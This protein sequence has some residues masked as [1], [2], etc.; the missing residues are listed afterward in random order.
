MDTALK[1]R[2]IG[3]IVLVALA[4]IFLPMLVKGPAPS[5][6]VAD[7][8]LEA[9]AAPANGQFETRE[10][11][12]VTPGDAPAGG[13]LGMRGAASAPAAVQDNPDAADLANPS[14]APS[15]PEV[16][17]GNY[18]VN[19]GA[20]ATSAD[21]DAVLARLKQ[22][23]LPGFSEKTQING[24][25]AW[26]VRVGPYVDQAQA[27]SARLQ[28]VKVRSDVNAQVVT[29]DANAAAPAPAAS[30][31][32]PAPAAKPSSSVAA[33]S[34]AAPTKTESLPPEPAKP[35]AA[36]PKPAEAPKPAPAKPD[37][38][39]TEPA[40]PEPT[41]PAVAAPAAPAAPAASSVGFA[42]QLGAFGRAEDAD[43]LRDRVRA[44]GFSAFVEQVRTD[45][46][47]LNRVRVG[48]VANRGDAEQLRAQ[49]A[50]KV[51]ISG[52]V[53]PHP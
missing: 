4:V 15:A 49:V 42:V 23:Q 1:Q 8:P 41:K 33:A 32:T 21:A 34:T 29:L 27:E 31:P 16:A 3:A 48:P 53:R 17:A 52:M 5:S 25:P 44:A 11:P 10:L 40:K 51:G 46:G 24:R 7:V 30:T 28:A 9:P 18:A 19:F 20:Y 45:K 47:A 37:V 26:R 2:L 14:S 36:A 12:L 39:K 38:A 22:A 35:V 43:A 6:G 13:A 50:A